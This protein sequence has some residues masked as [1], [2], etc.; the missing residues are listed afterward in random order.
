MTAPATRRS[1][2]NEPTSPAM[3]AQ[4]ITAASVVTNLVVRA[5]GLVPAR[6]DLAHVG[7]A[8]QQLGLTLGSVLVYLRTGVTARAAAEGWTHASVLARSLRPAQCSPR[9]RRSGATR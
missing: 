9:R 5:A 3:Q 4:M 2:A 8:D 6:L 7:T 1:Q